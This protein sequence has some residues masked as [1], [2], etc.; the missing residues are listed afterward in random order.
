MGKSVCVFV[1]GENFR[2]SIIELFDDFHKDDY[3][4]KQAEWT[5]FFNW[6]VCQVAGSDAERMRTY[7]Y[8]I[9][10]LDFFPYKFP[11][12]E[13]NT[14]KLKILLSKDENCAK[15]LVGLTGD[16]LIGRLKELVRDLK[17]RMYQM[18]AR[19]DGW[20]TLQNGIASRHDAIEFRRAGAIRFNLFDRSLGPEKAVD[21]MLAT[22]LLLLRDIYNV[23][24]IVSGDQDYVPAVQVVKDSGKRVI[25]VAFEARNGRLLPGGA[26][27]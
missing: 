24:V 3:L 20:T 4:P 8:V 18:R 21:V 13:H 16:R 6:L 19:F 26:S 25:N 22:D 11:D 1:D 9:E 12:A 5:R 2:Y 15:R 27:H 17:Q 23:A 10:H 7:W 14:D